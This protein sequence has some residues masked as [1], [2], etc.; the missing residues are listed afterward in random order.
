MIYV[1]SP[2][3]KQLDIIYSMDPMKIY[4]LDLPF[5]N[6]TEFKLI[7]LNVDIKYDSDD[8]F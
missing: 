4:N 8:D 7:T 3:M 1:H 2:I 6:L 5:Y